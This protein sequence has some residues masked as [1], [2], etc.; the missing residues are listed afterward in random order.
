MSQQQPRRNQEHI[1]HDDASAVQGEL[2]AAKKVSSGL[3][4]H[5]ETIVEYGV[6]IRETQLPRKSII[7]YIGGEVNS[8]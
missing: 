2:A 6:I 8:V 3:L 1:H 4:G 7:E 5:D